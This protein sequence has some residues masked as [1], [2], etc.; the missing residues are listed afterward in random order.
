MKISVAVPITW[1]VTNPT[2]TTQNRLKSMSRTETAM[3]VPINTSPPDVNI[4][5]L[6]AHNSLPIPAPSPV[7]T[8]KVPSTEANIP[9]AATSSGNMNPLESKSLVCPT[10]TAAVAASDSV[11][12]SD[13]T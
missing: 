7:R 10:S 11:A 4:P 9:I 5:V 3:P 8:R 12:I 6:S 13:P 2:S 1:P